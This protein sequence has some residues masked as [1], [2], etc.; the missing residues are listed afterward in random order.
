MEL[1]TEVAEGQVRISLSTAKAMK[2]EKRIP[3][4]LPQA[5]YPTKTLNMAI[6]AYQLAA[7]NQWPTAVAYSQIRIREANAAPMW[8]MEANA[9]HGPS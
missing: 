5:M 3:G 6:Q 1:Y 2:A 4:A 9:S 7:E 8:Q